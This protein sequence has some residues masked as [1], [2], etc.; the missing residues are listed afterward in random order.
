MVQRLVYIWY[1]IRKRLSD[2]A[3]FIKQLEKEL[4]HETKKAQFYKKLYYNQIPDHYIH[5]KREDWLKVIEENKRLREKF[6]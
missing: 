6:S 1:F 5:V 3:K 4:K 2:L